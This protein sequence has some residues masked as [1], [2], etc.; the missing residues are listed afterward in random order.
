MMGSI[1][2]MYSYTLYFGG[3]FIW[4]AYEDYLEQGPNAD[5]SDY[6]GGSIIAIMFSVIIGMFMVGSSGEKAK[7]VG[8]CQIAA[9]LT[10][11][12]I[13]HIPQVNPNQPGSTEIR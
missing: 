7:A 2:L 10:Y 1:Y 12:V 13:D 11:D 5:E 8:D 6:T 4:T 9:K 3:M